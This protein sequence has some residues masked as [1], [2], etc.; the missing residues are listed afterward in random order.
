MEYNMVRKCEICN[1]PYND[2]RNDSQPVC[3]DCR[4]RA[5]QKDMNKSWNTKRA[6]ELF[7]KTLNI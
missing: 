2:W 1:E 5:N 4:K 6:D 7:G 3:P